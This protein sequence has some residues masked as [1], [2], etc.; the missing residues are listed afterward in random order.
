MA[1]GSAPL[2]VPSLNLKGSHQSGQVGRWSHATAGSHLDLR[3]ETP[4]RF[5]MMEQ[6]IWDP[7]LMS[8]WGTGRKETCVLEPTSASTEAEKQC[9]S[10]SERTSG[11]RVQQCP[12]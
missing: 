7:L 11:A 10:E 6:E 8:A 4:E 12:M 3:A 1:R 5:W 9:N 2:Q